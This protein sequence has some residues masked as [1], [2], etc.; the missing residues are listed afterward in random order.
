MRPKLQRNHTSL[1][2]PTHCSFPQTAQRASERPHKVR[3]TGRNVA[4]AYHRTPFQNRVLNWGNTSLSCSWMALWCGCNR[5]GKRKHFYYKRCFF[6]NLDDIQN[7]NKKCG[8]CIK[9]G[10]GGHYYPIVNC[11]LSYLFDLQFIHFVFWLGPGELISLIFAPS[12]L[13]LQSNNFLKNAAAPTAAVLMRRVEKE[14]RFFF[15]F[16]PF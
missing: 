10:G 14:F 3:R 1:L 2:L 11:Q 9:E 12:H 15:H 5:C 4:R 13:P 6:F 7:N 8:Y 16:P